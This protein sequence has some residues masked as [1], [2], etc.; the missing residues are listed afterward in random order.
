MKE[1]ITAKIN[2]TVNNPCQLA[3]VPPYQPKKVFYLLNDY[4]CMVCKQT[5][6][7]DMGIP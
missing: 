1:P 3:L 5:K 2:I 7:L 6:I 4:G